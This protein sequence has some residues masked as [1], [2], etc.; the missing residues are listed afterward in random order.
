[1][2]SCPNSARAPLKRQDLIALSMPDLTIPVA[3]AAS[4]RLSE[5]VVFMRSV[6][7]SMIRNIAPAMVTEV[8][9]HVTQ[10]QGAAFTKY[11]A[12]I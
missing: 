10:S 9:T 4:A 7:Q 12:P 11:S 3:D 1:M 2:R 8:F 6:A 5:A